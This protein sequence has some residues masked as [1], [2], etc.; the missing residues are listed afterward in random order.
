MSA[1]TTYLRDKHALWYKFLLYVFSVAI[2]VFFFP[3]EGAFKYELEKLSGKP[4]NYEQLSAP[5]DFPVYKTA[6]ELAQEKSEI[7][8]TKKSYFFR[9]PSLLKTSGFESFLSRIKDKK[10]AFL[11]KQIND[12]IQKK[13]IIETS[14]VTAGK[15]NSFPVIVVEGN[16]QKD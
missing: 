15:K 5:F 10:T 2:I 1:L 14:E 3:G 11:C 7:E 13:D 6:K 9:N 12:S 16:I 4:W 8:Q